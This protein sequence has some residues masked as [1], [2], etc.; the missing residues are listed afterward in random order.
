M[1]HDPLLP[2][3]YVTAANRMNRLYVGLIVMNCWSTALIHLV[4]YKSVMKRRFYAIVCDCVLDFVTSVGILTVLL[5]IYSEDFDFQTNQFPVY[6]WYEDV[7]LVHV[8][9]EFQIVLATS[10]SD[11]RHVRSDYDWEHG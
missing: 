10:W 5:F 1:F 3:E 4:F 2:Y 8:L 7:W 9:S 6:K 11:A